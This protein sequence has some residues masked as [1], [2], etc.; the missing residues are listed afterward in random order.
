ME[1]E[2]QPCMRNITLCPIIYGSLGRW[3]SVIRFTLAPFCFLQGRLIIWQIPRSRCQTTR[4]R[5]DRLT[6]ME[7]KTVAAPDDVG[8]PW[9]VSD[10]SYKRRQEPKTSTENVPRHL[11]SQLTFKATW[12][13]CGLLKWWLKRNFCVRLSAPVTETR[14]KWL[15]GNWL[16]IK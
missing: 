15:T 9:L 3:S 16:V 10:M 12:G 11:D 2:R 5:T 8:P 6:S 13:W 14:A 7:G 4:P 1:K